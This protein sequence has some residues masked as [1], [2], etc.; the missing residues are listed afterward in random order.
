MRT[1]QRVQRTVFRGSGWGIQTPFLSQTGS[2]MYN[3]P[4]KNSLLGGANCPTDCCVFFFCRFWSC[5]SGTASPVRV[6]VS[7]EATVA[8]IP[9]PGRLRLSPSL[10]NEKHNHRKR[11]G[12]QGCVSAEEESHRAGRPGGAARR[13]PRPRPPRTGTGRRGTGS[14]VPLV[15]GEAGRRPTTLPSSPEPYA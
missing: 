11:A 5:C 3:T 14:C 6:P 8:H 2:L 12:R 15:S 7:P 13:L 1:G 4:A 9:F 10:F